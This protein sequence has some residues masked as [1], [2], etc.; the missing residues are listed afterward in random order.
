VKLVLEDIRT[1]AFAM[2]GKGRHLPTFQ[3]HLA[4]VG[5]DDWAGVESRHAPGAK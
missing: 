1:A 3:E 5:S 2:Q 4:V